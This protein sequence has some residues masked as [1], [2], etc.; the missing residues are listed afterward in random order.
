M[1]WEVEQSPVSPADCEPCVTLF[2]PIFW[3]QPTLTITGENHLDFFLLTYA[4]NPDFEEIVVTVG[5]AVN[6]EGVVLGALVLFQ[7]RSAVPVRFVNAS[8]V[9][10]TAAGA[11]VPYK[12]NSIVGLISCAENNW[13]FGGDFGF[14]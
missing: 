14:V 13:A 2:N 10:I 7:A 12:I 8:G 5:S 11:L 4:G 3:D 9:T 6:D 1:S